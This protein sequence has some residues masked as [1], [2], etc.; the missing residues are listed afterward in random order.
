MIYVQ[1]L[2]GIGHLQRS[3]HLAN[4]LAS[5]GFRVELVSGGMPQILQLVPGVRLSQLPPLKSPDSSFSRLVDES[6]RDIT[7]QR[8]QQRQQQLLDIFFRAAPQ[9]LITETFPFGRR[10]M[11]FE[12]LPL[13]EA[14][15][16][17]RDCMVISSIRDILQP[18]SREERNREICE[19]IGQYYDHVLVHADEKIVRLADSFELADQIESKVTYSGYISNPAAVSGS[20][21]RID[22]V[23]VS[24]GG[25]ATGLKLLQIAI[26][27]R[28]LSRFSGIPRRIL[29]SPQIA[30][31]DMQALQSQAE[32]GVI[33][34]RN[35]IDFLQLLNR[36]RLSVSQAGYNTI[37][38]ILGSDTKAVVVPFAEAG[39]VE[40]T[41]RAR[42]LDQHK[43]LVMLEEERLT[44]ISLADAIERACHLTSMLPMNLQGAH[45]SA[46]LLRQWLTLHQQNL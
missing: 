40:Q 27:A 3:V 37:T 32:N 1:H 6:G 26:E 9:I 29:V 43:R 28:P 45:N 25:S 4:A 39:E 7:P 19:L 13:L 18:K 14:A 41:R 8:K 2:L 46:L 12:L 20:V 22:E 38:D 11:R 36:A 30:E 34:E 15:Q 33:V 17:E 35:R 24:A 31:S 23:L 21:P 5:D 42:L 10:M 16:L 44:P